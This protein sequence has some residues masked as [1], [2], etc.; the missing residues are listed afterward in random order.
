MDQ[1]A[2]SGA[3]TLIVSAGLEGG[4][5]HYAS[6]VAP[7]WGANVAVWEHLIFYR[8]SRNLHQLV[9]DGLDPMALVCA[10]A[11]SAG[12]FFLPTLPLCIVGQSDPTVGRGLGR[13]SEFA[14]DTRHHVGPEDDTG[15]PQPALL[16]RMFSQHR[17]DFMLPAVRQERFEIFDEL[18]SR[19]ETD[20]VEVDLS[21]NNEFGPMTKLSRCQTELPEAITSWLRDLRA[22][23][24]AAEAAQGRRKRIYVRI[25][26]ASVAT[27]EMIGLEV[28]RWVTE[29]IVDGLV[30]ISSVKKQTPVDPLVG[31]DQDLELETVV[32][33][34]AGTECRVLAG[35][36]TNLTRPQASEATPPMIFGAALNCWAKGVDGFGIATGM[37]APNGWPLTETEYATLRAIGRPELLAT[38][39]KIYRAWAQ[40]AGGTPGDVVTLLPVPP[41]AAPHERLP[42]PL[43]IGS[44]A[45]CRVRVSDALE[46]WS[47]EG[48]LDTV[49]LTVRL[50]N[51]EHA[52][53]LNAVIV[54]LNGQEL[55]QTG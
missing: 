16:T 51:Y 3:D 11:R 48:R 43:E 42:Q 15:G 8:A 23:A 34:C 31:M 28:G 33:L 4:P 25:P 17:L 45:Q 54:R 41:T 27:W 36:T 44:T 24:V 20:G 6:A 52:G 30:A 39:H 49:T 13:T 22:V 10:R 32:A 29:R 55:P 53:D 47:N 1:L 40:N 46:H 38:E 7:L 12:L 9:G 5:V 2:G 18:L 50:A 14:Y 19:Y 21:L 26:A 35:F 37:W